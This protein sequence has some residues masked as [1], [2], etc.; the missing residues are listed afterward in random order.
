M[1][2]SEVPLNLVSVR[3]TCTWV[4]PEMAAT[5]SRSF[6]FTRTVTELSTVWVEE[7][8]V[9]PAARSFVETTACSSATRR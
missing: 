6:T 1:Y 5:A 4:M 7:R 2:T 3:D 9:A 8:T